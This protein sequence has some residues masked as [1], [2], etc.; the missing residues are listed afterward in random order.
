MKRTTTYT[1]WDIR[2]GHEP[3]GFELVPA[4]D[5]DALATELARVKAES[6]RVVPVGEPCEISKIAICG[7]FIFNGTVFR[8]YSFSREEFGAWQLSDHTEHLFAPNTI[9]QPVRIERWETEK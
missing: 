5:Y 3:P 6:L 4:S 2:T 9:V 7:C 1:A 8:M